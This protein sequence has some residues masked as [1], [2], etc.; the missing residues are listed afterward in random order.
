MPRQLAWHFTNGPQL[1]CGT[2]L[3]TGRTY[4]VEPPI[5]LCRRGL[6]ASVRLIDALTY[7]PGSTLSRVELSGEILTDNDKIVATDRR[8]L[9]TIDA[10]DLLRRFA[11][12]CALDVIDLW[13]APEIVVRW[14]RTG[15]ERCR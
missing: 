12:S 15:D 8:V 9:W 14:L 5:A 2:A 13:D 7:A 1:R 4:H 6:H 11:R 3:E 10:T